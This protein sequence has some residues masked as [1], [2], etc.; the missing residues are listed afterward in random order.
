[1]CASVIVTA[2][3]ALDDEHMHKLPKIAAKITDKSA[4]FIFIC[5]QRFY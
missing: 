4:S 2:L 5:H 1:M 3:N